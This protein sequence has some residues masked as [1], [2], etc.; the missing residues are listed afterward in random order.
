MH[1]EQEQYEYMVSRGMNPA[2]AEVWARI[3]ILQGVDCFPH[4]II[5]YVRPSSSWAD[6]DLTE[7]Y[8][9]CR[10]KARSPNCVFVGD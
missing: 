1:T 9:E 2:K 5:E 4:A 8:N 10:M 3:N 6:T 7:Y